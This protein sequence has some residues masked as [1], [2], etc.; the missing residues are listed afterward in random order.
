MRD[1]KFGSA[2]H[3]AGSYPVNLPESGFGYLS[4]NEQVLSENKTCI[5]DAGS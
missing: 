2:L 1:L 5:I 4:T 3:G